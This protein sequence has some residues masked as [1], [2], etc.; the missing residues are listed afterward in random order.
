MLHENTR[1]TCFH[2]ILP[3]TYESRHK[4]V[5]ASTKSCSPSTRQALDLPCSFVSLP[6]HSSLSS[7]N[8]VCLP[9]IDSRTNVFSMLSSFEHI[10]RCTVGWRPK[11]T[12]LHAV[13]SMPSR[14]GQSQHAR[15]PTYYITPSM[16]VKAASQF[17]PATTA[18]TLCRPSL[19]ETTR[20]S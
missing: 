7:H 9:R 10:A 6:A 2:A 8:N 19:H 15:C 18:C 11:T 5:P 3:S 4:S 12:E 14:T 1:P 20:I 17:M 13:S 16:P